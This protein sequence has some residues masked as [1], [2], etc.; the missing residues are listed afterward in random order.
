MASPYA[1]NGRLLLAETGETLPEGVMS[2]QT[3]FHPGRDMVGSLRGPVHH[4]A[5]RVHAST[6]R[7]RDHSGTVLGLHKFWG[8]PLED[9]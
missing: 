7:S 8:I 1:F 3:S 2:C 4:Y 6:Q 9:V 5:P